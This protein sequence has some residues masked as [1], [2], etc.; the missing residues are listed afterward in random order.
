MD[1][2]IKY[3]NIPVH[4][5][6]SADKGLIFNIQRYSIQDGPGIRTTI[7][8]KGCPLRCKWCSNPESQ[9]AYPEILV[10]V[11]KCQGCGKC[12]EMC[13]NDAIDLDDGV[14]HINRPLCTLC[15]KCVEVCPTGT[16]DI[17]GKVMTVDQ[18]VEEASRDEIFYDNSG[19]G[20]TLSGGEPL[21]QPEFAVNFLKKCK[22]EFSLN[23]A[24]DT[25]GYA[26]WEDFERILPYTD[27]ILFDLKNLDPEKHL[28]GTGVKNDIILENLRKIVDANQARV[29]VRIPVITG[30]NDSEE[31]MAQLAE[32][33]KDMPV[34]KISLLG[35]HEYG[36]PKYA[37]LGREYPY[38][39]T[40]FLEEGRLEQLK[41]FLESKG[42]T[43]TIGY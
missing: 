24:V 17:T 12:M 7:F 19:G 4:E 26:R 31:H 41:E 36:K 22:E 13:E 28:E 32:M 39:G 11:Q 30:Y 38:E 10:R 43:L 29:W 9:N 42:L 1:H 14:V 40:P 35:Y 15:M 23:T 20:V 37:F 16:L 5:Y 27:V 3:R 33:L 8:V 18:L 21:S 2:K 6:R 25:C 34:E